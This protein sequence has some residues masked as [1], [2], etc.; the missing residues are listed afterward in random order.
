[1]QTID[2]DRSAVN[3]GIQL[4]NSMARPGTSLFWRSGNFMKV[5][6]VLIGV[7]IRLFAQQVGL[8]V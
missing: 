8:E 6:L 5:D 2:C 3:A 1:M 7:S 4:K